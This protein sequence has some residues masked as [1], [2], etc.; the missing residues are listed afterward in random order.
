[1]RI[2]SSMKVS[3]LSNIKV[4]PLTSVEKQAML[5]DSFGELAEINATNLYLFLS[6]LQIVV[7]NYLQE[8]E[9]NWLRFEQS[10]NLINKINT[11]SQSDNLHSAYA[12]LRNQQGHERIA[13]DFIRTLEKGSY[14]L[15]YVRQLLTLQTITT[16]FTIKASDGEIYYTDKNMANYQ[17]VL[18]TFGASGNNFV[19][20]AYDVN[21]DSTIETLKSS[22]EQNLYKITG[23]DI[24]MRIM[25]VKD[26][27]LADLKARHPERA[28]SYIPR[29]DSTDAEIFNLLQQR[30]K[31]A[32][33][34]SLNRALTISTY[35]KM[36]KTMG[37]RGGY[38]TTSTQ[39][40]DVGLIQDKL[41]SQKTKQ[42]NFARQ[43]LIYNRFKELQ[44]ILQTQNM[45]EIKAG[46][47]RM[48]TERQSRV[49]D[50]ISKAVN[51]EAVKMIRELFE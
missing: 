22:I 48:F 43:T 29:F 16:N 19:S 7:T 3:N 32:D 1:M 30:L 18:S 8:Y 26:G 15:E 49:G 21:I 35:R 25:E 51:R 45:N 42:V 37:G 27:Y 31:N 50:N 11:I 36:R 9:R 47:L 33:V 6:Q 2:N 28:K 12:R 34:S 38:R 10:F 17:L 46:F 5:K 23:T 20:L 39:L 14:I 41:I 13:I 40:G 44:R 24:Y 4:D